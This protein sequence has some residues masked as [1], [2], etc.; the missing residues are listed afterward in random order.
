MRIEV[1]ASTDTLTR[2]WYSNAFISM[3]FAIAEMRVGGLGVASAGRVDTGCVDGLVRIDG[4]GVPVRIS[5]DPEAARRG[6]ALELI[7]CETVHVSAGD[8]RIDTTGSSL[9]LRIDQLVLRSER[10][11]SVPPTMPALSPDWESD[12]RLPV[13]IPAGDAGRGRVLGQSHNLGWAA[14]LDGVSLGPPTLVDGFANG[15][16]VPRRVAPS[17][18]YGLH[19]NSSIV[20]WFSLRLR[21]SQ[22]VL[23]VRPAPLPVG[24]TTVAMPTFIDPPRRGT[25]RSRR[26]A[27]GAAVGTGLFALVN[28]PSWPAAALAIAGVAAFAVTRREGARLPPALAASLFAVTSLLIMIEQVLER[29]PPDFG[30][31]KQFAEFHVLGVLTIL[32]LAVEYVRVP[33][34]PTRADTTE[35]QPDHGAF[36]LGRGWLSASVRRSARSVP[37]GRCAPS[38]TYRLL[39]L[40]SALRQ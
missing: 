29:H 7:A 12:V 30:W 15:W 6:E 40:H 23:A 35:Q 4:L 39:P 32:L 16:A 18:S 14:T 22:S 26:S 13:D 9:P 37:E 36:A 3:P 27:V 10:P 33:W 28:L 21:C 34:L 5:G 17:N 8:V 25:R 31:P 1:A 24:R 11:V 19:R 38:G 2:D 20:P